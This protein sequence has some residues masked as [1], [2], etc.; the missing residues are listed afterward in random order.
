[1][2]YHWVKIQSSPPKQRRDEVKR[3]AGNNDGDLVSQQIFFDAGGQAYALVKVPKNH[4]KKQAM[5]A[6]IKKN[7]PALGLVDAD[8]KDAGEQPPADVP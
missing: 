8:E 5:F 7:G 2:P 3:D 6:A 1:M 4:P